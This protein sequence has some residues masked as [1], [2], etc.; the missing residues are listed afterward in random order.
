MKNNWAFL[1]KPA[2]V[3]LLGAVLVFVLLFVLFDAGFILSLVLGGAAWFGLS[4]FL[5]DRMA[6][7]VAEAADRFEDKARA[8]VADLP[9]TMDKATK[10]AR[11]AAAEVSGAIDEQVSKLRDQGSSDDEGEI[12]EGTASAAPA[13][14]ASG[15]RVKPS[16]SLPGQADL[17]ARKGTWKYEG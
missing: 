4:K 5:T 11:D 15:P 16:K 17:A 10:A 14:G 6:A 2:N 7:E 8:A 1:Q 9:E 12:I 3:A 13:S